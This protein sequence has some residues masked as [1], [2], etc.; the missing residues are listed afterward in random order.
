MNTNNALLNAKRLA[1]M[2]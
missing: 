1:K 2:Y